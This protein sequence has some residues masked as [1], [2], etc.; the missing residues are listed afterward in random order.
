[1][2][3]GVKHQLVGRNRRPV[4]GYILASI[5]VGVIG[6]VTAI[7]ITVS[8]IMTTFDDVA[9]SYDDLFETGVEVGPEVTSVELEDAKYTVLSFSDRS[10]APSV[11]EQLEQCEITDP[12][13]EPVATNASAQE[14]S[15][16]DVANVSQH[17][18]SSQH[19]IYTHFEAHNGTHGI[20]CE[21]H[22]FLSDSANY[23]MGSTAT[24][25]ILI[26]LGSVGI[27]GG[28]FMMGV[29]NSSRNKKAQS[30]TFSESEPHDPE[31]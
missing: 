24:G 14:I 26:G 10:E 13:G 18:P 11:T 12:Y 9:E 31:L 21:Q 16:A 5:V 6:L 23:P 27:A 20:Q 28:L 4:A 3:D 17:R 25:G 22:S 2:T 8:G 1:M 19:V 7:L 15:E 30:K 29:L